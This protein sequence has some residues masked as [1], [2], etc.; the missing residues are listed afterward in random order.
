[1]IL[2]ILNRRGKVS[3]EADDL[4]AGLDDPKPKTTPSATKSDFMSSL[5]GT[6]TNNNNSSNNVGPNPTKARDFVL[7]EKYKTPSSSAASEESSVKP[8]MAS[9]RSR[10][11]SPFMLPTTTSTASERNS[12]PNP[13]PNPPNQFNF[14][15]SSS[16]NIVDPRLSTTNFDTKTSSYPQVNE[17]MK[18]QFDR[19]GEFEKEQQFKL[20]KDLEEHKRQL[21]AQQAEHR[22]ILGRSVA[23]RLNR[24]VISNNAPLHHQAC[25]NL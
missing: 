23:D 9:Q 6:K 8:P 5:F 14:E 12:A 4:F 10:R 7:E 19:L 13:N 16:N 24:I 2:F 11:G 1:M 3:D 17:T 21:D 20:V 15:P 25:N 18:H 22:M